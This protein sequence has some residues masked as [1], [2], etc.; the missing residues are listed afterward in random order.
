M[1]FWF[2]FN[3]FIFF[4]IFFF[5]KRNI[6]ILWTVLA[7]FS[8]FRYN[9]GADYLQYSFGFQE[10]LSGNEFFILGSDLF[11]LALVYLS[12][13]LELNFQFVI[14]IY[15]FLTALFF[16]NGF[17]YYAKNNLQ[18][19]II[20]LFYI[21]FLY[22]TGMNGI[23]Q[24]LAVGIFLY[25]SRYIIEKKF[26]IYLL[27]IFFATAVHKSAAFLLPLYFLGK[28]KLNIFVIFFMISLM[29]LFLIINPIHY[30]EIL[31]I[32]LNIPFVVYFDY[33]R[34]GEQPSVYSKIITFVSILMLLF[35]RILDRKDLLQNIVFNF[36]LLMM[37]I[38]VIALNMDV[39]GR[40]SLYFRPFNILFFVYI[41]IFFINN[42]PSMKNFI[43]TSSV[44][45][46]FFLAIFQLYI[47]A[48]KSNAY[49]QFAFN[50]S[51]YGKNNIIQVFGNHKLV[52]EWEK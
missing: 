6:Y 44:I 11:H 12:G 10:I 14:A 49:E 23:R 18:I 34:F 52:K 16:Y 28:I 27:F 46:I 39:M 4:I 24:I 20:T 38:K 8:A 36:M 7:L 13:Y 5:K 30:I 29:S 50:L 40:L 47:I 43:I 21:T 31:M 37:I 9:I 17:Q 2:F 42:K 45:A 15:S 22:Y 19:I 35:L 1:Y 25:G 32:K 51:V 26:L 41:I 3:S 48:N 33:G